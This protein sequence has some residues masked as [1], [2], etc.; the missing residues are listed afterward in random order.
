MSLTVVAYYADL[1]IVF[2][3]PEGTT[4]ETEKDAISVFLVEGKAPGMKVHPPMDKMGMRASPTSEITFEECWIPEENLLGQ[5]RKGT[6]LIQAVAR[7]DKN[8]T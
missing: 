4:A 2:A 6:E 7:A 1:V 3:R 8:V 5:E